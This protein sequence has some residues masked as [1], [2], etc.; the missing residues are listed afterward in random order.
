MQQQGFS[1]RAER[2]RPAGSQEIGAQG[3]GMQGMQGQGHG[4]MDEGDSVDVAYSGT[5]GVVTSF[6]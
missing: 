5:A 6:T 3:Q 1:L 4:Q 2:G